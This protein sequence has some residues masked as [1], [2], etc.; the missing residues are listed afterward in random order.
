MAASGKVCLSTCAAWRVKAKRA[1]SAKS[2][3]TC[4]RACKTAWSAAT[5]YATAQGTSGKNRIKPIQFLSIAVP[6]PPLAEQQ[7]IVARLGE[8]AE[9]THQLEAHLDANEHDVEHLLALRFRDAI[10]N[11]PMRPMAEVA[12]L[13]RRKA[14][15]AL[16]GSYPE[17]G[18]RSFGKGTFH[19]PPLSGAEVGTKRLFHIEPGDLIF[20]NVFAWE[21]AIA[22]AQSKDAGRFGSHRFMTCQTNPTRASA[23]FLCYYFL[24]DDGLLKIGDASPGGAGRNRTLGQEKLMAIE[25][26]IPP[27]PVQQSFNRLQTE[28]TAL[29]NQHAVLR[30]ANAALLPA[31][32]ER[33]FAQ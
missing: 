7:A 1:A 2:S 23:E 28:I 4:S 10:A 27:L 20:S 15:I 26:P 14:N 17:I 25:V 16:D 11:A 30:A 3:P 29:K 19:K 33:V 9:K 6:L 18:I 22:I 12:P 24:T 21:G 31:A 8:L 32:L 13:V 5:C